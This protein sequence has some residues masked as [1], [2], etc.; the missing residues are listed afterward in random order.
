MADAILNTLK[1]PCSCTLL[2]LSEEKRP[3]CEGVAESLK[4]LIQNSGDFI[5][6]SHEIVEIANASLC[7]FLQATVTG[8]PLGWDVKHVVP[9]ETLLPLSSSSEEE[10]RL[11]LIASLSIDGEAVYQRLPCVELFLYAKILLSC[12]GLHQDV[13]L[14]RARLRVNAWHQRLLNQPSPS[15][16]TKI[17]EDLRA[18]ENTISSITSGGNSHYAEFLLEEAAVHLLHGYDAKAITI[19]KKAA[20]ENDFEF[21]LTGR[22][23]KRTKFQQKD[24][25]QLVVL[26]RSAKGREKQN[27]KIYSDDESKLLLSS[28]KDSLQPNALR[29]E[30]DTLLDSIAF[31][32]SD[33]IKTDTQVSDS[34]PP[35]LAELDPGNQPLL[36]P[37]DA[38][39]LLNTASSITKHITNRRNYSRRDSSVCRESHIWRKLELASLYAGF[40]DKKSYRGL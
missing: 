5:S 7:A 2:G 33:D 28:L 31:T 24:I 27:E 14:L 11:Q 23:G 32:R 16:E 37:L 34:L 3:R 19:L 40:V 36:D 29:L 22:L 26:A 15:L 10:I 6:C 9:C 25:S 35:S 21:V 17:Y 38:I 20:K 30:D 18:V 39:I 8:P 12:I 4:D 1:S 13:G